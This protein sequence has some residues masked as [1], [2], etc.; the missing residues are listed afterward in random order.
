MRTQLTGTFVHVTIERACRTNILLNNPL[1]EK[2][3]Y[4]LQQIQCMY[5]HL[6]HHI[7]QVMSLQADHMAPVG[8]GHI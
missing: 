3:L 8:W 6:P 1:C 4:Y 7:P 2:H 5:T